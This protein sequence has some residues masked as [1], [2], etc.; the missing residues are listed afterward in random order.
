MSTSLLV[1]VAAGL[2]ISQVGTVAS[3]AGSLSNG[4]TASA[5]TSVYLT[6]AGVLTLSTSGFPAPGAALYV[7]LAVVVASASTITSIT[8]ARAVF[9]VVGGPVLSALTAGAT[10][11]TNE[12]TMLQSV[13]NA[14]RASGAR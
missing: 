5:T 3:Y 4:V 10:Y 9:A 11:G 2:F 6:N 8:D 12:Q 7:P 14:V 13:Y 1:D